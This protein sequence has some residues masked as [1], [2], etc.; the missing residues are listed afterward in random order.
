MSTYY[1]IE[2]KIK[3][4][5]FLCAL[6][7][8]GITE[9]LRE[10]S[11][12]GAHQTPVLTDGNNYLTFYVGDDGTVQDLTCR[13]WCGAPGRILSGTLLD[14]NNRRAGRARRTCQGFDC[15]LAGQRSS[16]GRSPRGMQDGDRAR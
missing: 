16:A 6:A 15:A 5:D 3:V 7:K 4:A 14:R 13:A 11:E 2:K 9:K 12:D 8:E 1:R 10:P